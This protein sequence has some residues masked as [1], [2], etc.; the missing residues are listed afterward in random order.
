MKIVVQCYFEYND[1]EDKDSLEYQRV[2]NSI[3]EAIT[4]CSSEREAML[5]D[6]EYAYLNDVFYQKL[7]L[8]KFL[9][10]EVIKY[11]DFEILPL[12]V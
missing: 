1:P 3:E 12:L 8:D 6:E 2:F 7:P 5:Y 4:Y 9:S 11:S 10:G